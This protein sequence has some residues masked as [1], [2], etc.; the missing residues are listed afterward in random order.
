MWN[1]SLLK[2]QFGVRMNETRVGMNDV[3]RSG[4]SGLVEHKGQIWKKI[5]NLLL[6]IIYAFEVFIF[7]IWIICDYSRDIEFR[8]A[9]LIEAKYT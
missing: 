3:G 8:N 1:Y 4:D 7:C 2:R 5:H 9:V 6:D